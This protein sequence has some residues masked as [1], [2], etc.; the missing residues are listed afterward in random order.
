M[1]CL[2]FSDV[3]ISVSIGKQQKGN[4]IQ[5]CWSDCSHHRGE[6]IDDRKCLP[7]HNRAWMDE[8]QQQCSRAYYFIGNPTH[9]GINTIRT[10]WREKVEL[11]SWKPISTPDAHD[12]RDSRSLLWHS[13]KPAA[14][15]ERHFRTTLWIKPF[16]SLVRYR[17]FREEKI[18]KDFITTIITWRRW[19]LLALLYPAIQQARSTQ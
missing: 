7:R 14:S 15:V 13:A 11:G 5:S 9:G 2:S 3:V 10:R 8:H 18:K 12:M 19:R 1:S 6:D 17:C 4:R 16:I